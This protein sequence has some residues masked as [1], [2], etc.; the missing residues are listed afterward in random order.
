MN[1]FNFQPNGSAFEREIAAVVSRIAP[2]EAE[3]LAQAREYNDSLCKPLGSL[4]KMEEIRERIWAI[5]RGNPQ[6]FQKAVV[7]YAG[8]NG[9]CQEGV[10]TNPQDITYKVCLNI[11]SGRSGLGRI[12]AFYHVEVFLE[13]LAVLEDVEGHT[14]YK[15]RRSTDNMRL[16]PAMSRDDAAQYVLAGIRRTQ[17][18]IDSGYNLIGAGEM[19]VGNTT[20]SSAVISLLT[21]VPPEETTGFGSGL[22]RD[23]VR[24]KVNVVRDALAING[25]YGDILD[26]AAKLAGADICAMAGTYLACAANSIPFVLD[27]VISMA[28]LALARGFHSGILEYAFSSHKTKESGARA[29][30]QAFGL[31]PMLDL[32][33]RLGEGSGC[34]L[35]M[36]LME[37]SMFTLGTMA[38]FHDV[39]VNKQDYVDIREEK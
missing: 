34:P 22:T 17:E 23:G 8:D 35:A 39:S 25:P 3:Y 1:S 10:S 31:R 32:E 24:H 15:V 9:V 4:G 7:V 33:M 29:V 11:L 21:G 28:A 20:T 19:G 26:A 27:G 2:I 37:C 6:P 13:D 36:N 30:E 38:S 16:G 5:T 12:A 18:L 14:T